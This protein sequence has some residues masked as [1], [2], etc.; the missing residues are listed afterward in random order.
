M[1][2]TAVSASL[3]LR[4]PL[5]L[6]QDEDPRLGIL[7][8]H[9][10]SRRQP[11]D[12]AS[13]YYVVVHGWNS[14]GQIYR[15]VITPLNSPFRRAFSDSKKPLRNGLVSRPRWPAAASDRKTIPQRTTAFS[16]GW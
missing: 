10:H 8:A 14:G 3:V 13:D 12:S 16:V 15:R 11:Y 2:D 7:F 9:S 4:N 1:D 6:F 5:L